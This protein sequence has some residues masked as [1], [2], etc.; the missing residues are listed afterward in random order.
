VVV[1][2]HYLIGDAIG[3]LGGQVLDFW[4]QVGCDCVCMAQTASTLCQLSGDQL[5][6]EC[7][8]RGL[9]CSGP[10][11]EL[12]SRLAEFLRSSAMDQHDIQASVPAGM[13]D[14]GI[15]PP[16]CTDENGQ[17]SVLVDLLRQVKPPAFGRS[18]ID[19]AFL[20]QVGRNT[21]FRFS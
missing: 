2:R 4:G 5:R 7:E 19:Y 16:R 9:S 13:V 12:R 21:N 3:R 15:N 17:T 18:R 10:V 8:E 1:L 20:Y 6:V 14:T 11:R